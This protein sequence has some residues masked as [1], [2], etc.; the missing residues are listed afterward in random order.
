MKSLFLV[1]CAFKCSVICL[2]I[3][4]LPNTNATTKHLLLNDY[5]VKIHFKW[6]KN[7]ILDIAVHL[8]LMPELLVTWFHHHHAPLYAVL[9]YHHHDNHGKHDHKP[10][11][12]LKRCCVNTFMVPCFAGWIQS[13]KTVTLASERTPRCSIG[14]HCHDFCFLHT[15]CIWKYTCTLRYSLWPSTVGFVG[16]RFEWLLYIAVFLCVGTSS[17]N[18]V[19]GTGPNHN[20][21]SVSQSQSCKG[22]F[23]DE[24]HKLV[25]N[26][27]R[28]AMNLSQGKRGTKHQQ[29]T[30]P[31]GHNYDVRPW[32]FWWFRGHWWC[33]SKTYFS[34]LLRWSL[35]PTWAVSTP[36][37]ASCAQASLRLWAA[38][39][40]CPTLLLPL[41][42]PW[43]A[44]CA[45]RRSTATHPHLTAPSGPAP[46]RTPRAACWPPRNPW[47]SFHRSPTQ[48][49]PSTSALCKSQSA[50]PADPT[51]R[52]HNAGPCR[53]RPKDFGGGDGR[54]K[55]QGADLGF[56]MC[57]L[58]RCRL[59]GLD[60]WGIEEERADE[61]HRAQPVKGEG[62]NEKTNAV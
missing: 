25:D 21:P 30:V 3:P 33:Y 38:T 34:S 52:P 48:Y 44:P 7:N 20:Q 9:P 13:D 53:A 45:P 40:P 59:K 22:M 47:A 51:W 17:T 61:E 49:R 31:Q 16:R 50:T 10:Q 57:V 8:K 36:L 4:P 42:G 37:R 54:R 1:N 29:Q 14:P 23:T 15:L 6:I 12:M 46:P 41:W 39:R 58:L 19:A 60:D 55:R 5:T 56:G 35:L 62:E 11:A 26:W 2:L 24:L 43:R 28:D 32:H 18:T 27:A